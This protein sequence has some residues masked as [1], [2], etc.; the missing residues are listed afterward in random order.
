M[1]LLGAQS[2][3]RDPSSKD[4][5]S[6]DP[7]SAA[8]AGGNGAA[9]GVAPS[10]VFDAPRR[11]ERLCARWS[12]SDAG[13][14][15]GPG[16]LSRAVSSTGAVDGDNRSNSKPVD[17]EALALPGTPA[18]HRAARVLPDQRTARQDASSKPRQAA[19]SSNMLP[20]ASDASRHHQPGSIT[21]LRQASLVVTVK[22]TGCGIKPEDIPRL[23]QP[24]QQTRQGLAFTGASSGLGLFISRGIVR[25]MGG[26][27]EVDSENGVGSEFRFVVPVTVVSGE[28][29]DSLVDQ[30]SGIHSKDASPACAPIQRMG[31]SGTPSRSGKTAI[32]TR[33]G[34][35]KDAQA[36][37]EA[38][39]DDFMS[40][41]SAAARERS[42]AS[43]PCFRS[44]S[45]R[46]G[47]ASTCVS[48][49]AT[50]GGL[51]I[52]GPNHSGASRPTVSKWR[53]RGHR[54]PQAGNSDSN[55][56]AS[57]SMIESQGSLLMLPSDP[58]VD[59][60]APLQARMYRLK[61]GGDA[62]RDDDDEEEEGVS[63]DNG[64]PGS[65]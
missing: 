6:K 42:D 14:P 27:M 1:R 11:M 23:F 63:L 59:T 57:G 62:A 48:H 7:S 61:A 20:T 5:S 36:P 18:S 52:G 10:S 21:G 4:P 30:G 25:Q 38:T 3:S 17:A 28:V 26:D 56:A 53:N 12:S 13:A 44:T 43:F 32:S 49:D 46:E 45:A 39:L 16:K 35:G 60:A 64:T 41:G 8:S 50:A 58:R 33:P 22:D 37:T 51:G 40:L 31:S 55:T 2:T 54:R 15:R 34:T 47:S 9:E 29:S 19:P 65:M 24:F